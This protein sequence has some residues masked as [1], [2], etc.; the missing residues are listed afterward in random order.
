[1]ISASGTPTLLQNG[2]WDK[3]SDPQ[4]GKV[5]TIARY[6][7]DER[8]HIEILK[9]MWRRRCHTG[10]KNTNKKEYSR[11]LVSECHSDVW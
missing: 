11:Y 3:I 10:I 2:R 6:E 5:F 8:Y 4:T 1:M 7:S 9:L